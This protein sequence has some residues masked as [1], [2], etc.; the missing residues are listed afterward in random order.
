MMHASDVDN[1]DDVACFHGC[2]QQPPPFRS[3]VCLFRVR[4]RP[5]GEAALRHRQGPGDGR[6]SV[7]MM[8]ARRTLCPPH[9]ALPSS[10]TTRWPIN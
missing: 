6:A 2:L 5:Q 7:A 3:M 1:T 9:P 4:G 8:R 10:T